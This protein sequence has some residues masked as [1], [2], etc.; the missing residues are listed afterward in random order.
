[1][2]DLALSS[3]RVCDNCTTKTPA[4]GNKACINC[5]AKL[6]MACVSV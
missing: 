5:T 2:C 3:C 1:M 4:I 6:N